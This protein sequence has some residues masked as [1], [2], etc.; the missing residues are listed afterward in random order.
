MNW[1]YNYVIAGSGG[2][3]EVAYYDLM[4]MP[5][6]KYYKGYT[7][8]IKG[9]TKQMLCRLCFNL[10]VNKYISTPFR[11]IVFP[12]LFPSNFETQKPLCYLFFGNQFAVINTGYIEYLRKKHP[13]AKF[14][15]YM[16]DIV[17]SLPYYDI[18][19]YKQRFDLILSYDRGDCERY[20]LTYFPT[21]YSYYPIQ[22]PKKEDI[23][24]FFCGAA[25]TRYKTILN[26]YQRLVEQGLKC[27]FFIIGVPKDE[28][29]HG[30]GLI[31]DQRIS[32]IENL[33]Y[34]ASSKCILEIMQ[35][36]A[37]G[38]TP[39]LWEAIMYDKLLLTNNKLIHQSNYN[40]YGGIYNTMTDLDNARNW[41]VGVHQYDVEIK[42]DKSPLY[43]MTII[44][45][46]L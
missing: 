21:P 45:K 2:F 27:K 39:R 19:S 11:R 16:Q 17:S 1:K 13:D 37:D 36:N 4:Q 24:V 46:N 23:D 10:V 42:K 18:E 3:Y 9:R 26:V 38:F 32:Y 29:I 25:K 15:L 35:E 44:D 28:Q 43:L 8:G 5:N 41:I 14:V 34:V 30:E 20:N 12:W 22:N 40:K 7:D 33:E 6:V 31:Y